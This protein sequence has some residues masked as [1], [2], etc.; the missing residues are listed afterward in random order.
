MKNRKNKKLGKYEEKDVTDRYPASSGV[1]D[2]TEEVIPQDDIEQED[3]RESVQEM[4]KNAIQK[5]RKARKKNSTELIDY[6][7]KQLERLRK[8]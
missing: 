3:K 7:S 6:Y 2:I 5:L 8:E 4:R 1:Q